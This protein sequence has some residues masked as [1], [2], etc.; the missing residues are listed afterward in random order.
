MWVAI[1]CFAMA[2][3]VL[4]VVFRQARFELIG[5]TLLVGSLMGAAYALRRFFPAH[6]FAKY[7]IKMYGKGDRDW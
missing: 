3:F 5:W 1:L 6:R 2:T 7:V 4:V